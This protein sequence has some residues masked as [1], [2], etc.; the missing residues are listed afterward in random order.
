[1]PW[2]KLKTNETKPG[3]LQYYLQI[4][5]YIYTFPRC[6]FNQIFGTI[7]NINKQGNK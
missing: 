6:E 1:M 2:E 4:Q 5:D 3:M 7:A